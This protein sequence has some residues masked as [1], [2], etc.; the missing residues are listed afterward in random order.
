[1]L[2]ILSDVLAI[3]LQCL[4][5]H[6]DSE[7]GHIYVSAPGK[8]RFTATTLLPNLKHAV[9]QCTQAVY[10]LMP[11]ASTY[12]TCKDSAC[13]TEPQVW[14]QRVSHWCKCKGKAD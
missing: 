14:P 2:G 3:L 6:V 11:S 1:M 10:D 7:P 12:N 9:L 8:C 4:Q 13:I 5:P